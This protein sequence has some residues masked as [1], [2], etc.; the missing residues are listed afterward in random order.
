MEAGAIDI[1]AATKPWAATAFVVTLDYGYEGMTR[2]PQQIKVFSAAQELASPD[3]PGELL[4]YTAAGHV[5]TLTSD[6]R[7]AV[8]VLS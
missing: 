1:A 3:G 5:L 8:R 7:V 6:G 4:F 2:D